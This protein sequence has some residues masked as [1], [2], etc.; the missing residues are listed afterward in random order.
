MILLT[1]LTASEKSPDLVSNWD[2][3][4]EVAQHIL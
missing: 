1:A 4:A 3:I 2:V